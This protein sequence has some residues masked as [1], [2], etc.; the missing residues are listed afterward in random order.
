MILRWKFLWKQLWY[1]FLKSQ[2]LRSSNIICYR[3]LR[4]FIW[5]SMRALKHDSYET[6]NGF[7]N[8]FSYGIG[9]S[10]RRF[11]GRYNVGETVSQQCFMLI[12][13]ADTCRRKSPVKLWVWT[14]IGLQNPD[15]LISSSSSSHQPKE[16][17]CWTYAFPKIRQTEN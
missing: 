6:G 10:T 2:K 14:Q 7:E 8:F 11:S 1:T 16:I 17:Q 9:L 12:L 13:R 5:L 4:F 3:K 15:M